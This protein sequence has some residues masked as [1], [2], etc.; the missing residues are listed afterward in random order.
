MTDTRP[1][2]SDLQIYPV[3]AERWADLETLFGEKGAFSGC[4]CQFWR[5]SRAEYRRLDGEGHK[6][7]MCELVSKNEVPG[8]LAYVDGQPAGWCS[9]GPR[10]DFR[11]LENSRTLKQVDDQPVWSIVCFFV[12]KPFRGRG[13]LVEL[14]RGAVTYAAQEGALVVEAYPVDASDGPVHGG[15]RGY[16]GLISAFRRAG[17][18]EVARRSPRQAVMRYTVERDH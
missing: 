7:A 4:W 5:M 11:A 13:L 3:T 18:V 1:S 10:E 8:I 15:T 2:P 9:I 14:L 16:M 6:A 12:A 17:F